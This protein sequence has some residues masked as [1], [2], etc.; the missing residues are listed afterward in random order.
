MTDAVRG[1]DEQRSTWN[2]ILHVFP[3]NHHG[4]IRPTELREQ[5]IKKFLANDPKLL[6]R[7]NNSPP[8][9]FSLFFMAGTLMSLNQVLQENPLCT[10]R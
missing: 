10:I 4:K 6:R 3:Q 8:I 7:R 1:M 9:L 2:Y 5:D